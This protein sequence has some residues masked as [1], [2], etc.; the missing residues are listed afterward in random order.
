MAANGGRITKE[1]FNNKCFEI[2]Y[3]YVNI[4]AGNKT[5]AFRKY[6]ID[7]NKEIPS[8]NAKSAYAFFEN[9]LV[10]DYIKKFR[11]ENHK[12]L[13]SQ[14]ADN[15]AMLLSIATNL[16]TKD[17]DKISAIKELN[18]MCGY[19][20]HNINVEPNTITIEFEEEDN[21]ADKTKD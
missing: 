20:I 13:Q 1:E 5:E 16:K 8:S 18:T 17:R 12:L 7:N 15:I 14:R 11:E 4:T 10:K 6:C 3:N 21:G 9:Q 2:A 19:N